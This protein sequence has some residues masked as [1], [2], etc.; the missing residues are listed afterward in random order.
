MRL[1]R[2]TLK[3]FGVFKEYEVDFPTDVKTCILITGQNNAGKTTIIRGLRLI[4][5]ALRGKL[6]TG[7]LLKRDTSSIDTCKLV[8]RFQKGEATIQATFDNDRTV[9]VWLDGSDG[10]V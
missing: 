2:L 6:D 10:T 7:Q 9:S 5:S 3:N 4:A 1:R 8:H